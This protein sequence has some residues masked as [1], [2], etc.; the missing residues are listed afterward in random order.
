[1]NSY[2]TIMEKDTQLRVHI[3]PALGKLPL[4]EVSNEALTEFF[5]WYQPHEVSQLLAAARDEWARTVLLFAVHTG[6]RVGEQRAVR[7][8]DIDFEK[9][10]IT[11]RR[12]APK[13]LV[14]EKSPKSNRRRRVDLTPELAEALEKIRHSRE[15]VFCNSEA[16]RSSPRS[17]KAAPSSCW[18]R[19]SS[20]AALVPVVQATDLWELD[21]LAG[22]GR[23]HRAR[24]GRVLAERQMRR[25]R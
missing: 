12:S 18:D 3:L 22:I 16:G 14:V 13:W 23:H 19:S 8:S 11:I 5:D 21:H 24:R 6:A 20:G 15:T 25:E 2:T 9:G 10:I 4:A 7:W 17:R 1:V